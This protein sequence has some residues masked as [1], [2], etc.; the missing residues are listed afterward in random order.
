M[1]KE[2]VTF[3]NILLLIVCVALIL[4]IFKSAF[5]TGKDQKIVSDLPTMNEV[6]EL[7]ELKTATGMSVYEMQHLPTKTIAKSGI[8][9]ERYE[10]VLRELQIKENQVRALTI[11]SGTIKDSLK[12]ARL[13][14]DEFQNKVWKWEKIL[15]SGTKTFRQMSEK[16]SI[17]HE[18]T[19]IAVAVIDKVEGSGR[20]ARFYTDF[21]SLDSTNIKF[22][23]ASVFRKENAEIR[24][25]LQVD[26]G[27]EFQ[28]S[29]L[30]PNA[31][32]ISDV[33]LSLFPDGQIIPS[34]KVGG[35]YDVQNGIDWFWGARVK[36]NLF[37]I[38]KRN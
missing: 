22:N 38:K 9:S 26:V 16:D 36:Y 3:K 19:D 1:K 23:G 29:F 6:E 14:R 12:L 37:K 24:D 33:Q 15:P 21:Y 32:V 27:A 20:K 2:H 13:E 4:L 18:S 11:V 25:I 17:L 30:T 31:R 8:P 34:V 7:N 5:N 28:K 10:A 35:V